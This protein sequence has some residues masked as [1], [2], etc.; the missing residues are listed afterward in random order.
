MIPKNMLKPPYMS[1]LIA[2][3]RDQITS[4]LKAEL[5]QKDQINSAIVIYCNYMKME[6]K[7][8][9]KPLLPIYNQIYY[10]GN[11]RAILSENNIDE[12]ITLSAGEIDA[13]IKKFLNN[14]FGWTFI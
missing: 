4:V 7:E 12:H 5:R 3:A 2:S 1:Q 11:M 9:G 10:S 8:K 6:K 13:K 14:R